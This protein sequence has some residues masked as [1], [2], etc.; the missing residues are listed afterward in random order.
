MESPLVNDYKKPFIIRRLFET[1][2]GGLRLFGSEGAP[3]YVYL[4]QMLIFSMIP[5]F[6]TLFVLLE[7]NEMISLHQAVIISGVLDGVYSLV[8]QLLAYFLRTQKSKS[9]EI[10][11]VNLATDEEVIEFDSPFGPKTWEFLIKEK[12]MKG[13]IV[14]HSIIAGLVGAGVVYYVR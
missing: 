9:G 4:L 6:T 13:A 2:L 7:H 3:L 1:F 14:V 8:L 11:Q 12:K 5:I 10:E